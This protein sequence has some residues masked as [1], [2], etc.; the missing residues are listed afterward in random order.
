MGNSQSSKCN[1]S[2]IAYKSLPTLNINDDGNDDIEYS[3]KCD[4]NIQESSDRFYDEDPI[5]VELFKEHT[6]NATHINDIVDKFVTDNEVYKFI[7]SITS[8]MNLCD[9]IN[10]PVEFIDHRVKTSNELVNCISEF[11]CKELQKKR[12][13]IFGV[14]YNIVEILYNKETKTFD[15]KYFTSKLAG[16]CREHFSANFMIRRDKKLDFMAE[17]YLKLIEA[18]DLKPLSTGKKISSNDMKNIYFNYNNRKP[19]ETIY[20]PIFI[21]EI[22]KLTNSVSDNILKE[23]I[24]FQ[25]IMN[26]QFA[27]IVV[28]LY[29]GISTFRFYDDIF[30]INSGHTMFDGEHGFGTYCLMCRFYSDTNNVVEY[31]KLKEYVRLDYNHF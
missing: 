22:V 6:K 31:T 25:A 21:N 26:G 20:M 28:L 27:I 4:I 16:F 8:L 14:H 19:N 12:H 29:L 7:G 17:L 1:G 11:I 30:Y 23:Q 3:A 13:N 9:K 2:H 15:T 18:K 5:K 24:F 10:K